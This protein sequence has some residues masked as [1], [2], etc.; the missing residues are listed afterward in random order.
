MVNSDRI[1]NFRSLEYNI[2]AIKLISDLGAQVGAK[3]E[4]DLLNKR[5]NE[6]R[7]SVV[8]AMGRNHYERE[9]KATSTLIGCPDYWR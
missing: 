9:L 2:N 7:E 6:I 8:A 1:R 4:M 5:L 3:S